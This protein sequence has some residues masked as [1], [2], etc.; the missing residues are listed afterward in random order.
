MKV[1]L[2]VL[3]FASGFYAYAE[4]E[5]PQ[6]IYF[7]GSVHLG[8]M[9]ATRQ[10]SPLGERLFLVGNLEPQTALDGFGIN[11]ERADG[12]NWGELEFNVG[13]KSFYGD[14]RTVG[15]RYQAGVKLVNADLG[16]VVSSD[17]SAARML[18]LPLEE[19]LEFLQIEMG[20][21]SRMVGPYGGAFLDFHFGDAGHFVYVGSSFGLINLGVDYGIRSGFSPVEI[22][23]E[24]SD[25]IRVFKH[26]VGWGFQM[27]DSLALNFGYEFSTF[28]QAGLSLPHG[29]TKAVPTDRHNFK[30][31]LFHW[32]RRK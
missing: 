27:T 5:L 28:G 26:E 19:V 14:Q 22:S 16:E 21:D 13:Y 17:G 2:A 9:S 15:I 29:D 10:E 12:I 11:E 6:G 4:E 23:V 31:S 30:L 24:S 3:F 18:D 32:W 1:C 8:P 7:S 20:G 25:W